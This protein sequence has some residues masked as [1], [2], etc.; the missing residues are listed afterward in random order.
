MTVPV[1]M[2]VLETLL[3][4]LDVT[5]PDCRTRILSFRKMADAACDSGR[6]TLKQWRVLQ[7]HVSVIQEKCLAGEKKP[8]RSGGTKRK[9]DQRPRS[10]V[11][12]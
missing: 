10:P 1:S 7:E 5:K 8:R 12:C 11:M 9:T 3:L 2:G 4:E 6:I